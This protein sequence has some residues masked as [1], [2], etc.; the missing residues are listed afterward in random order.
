MEKKSS[1]V[2][3]LTNSA[4]SVDSFEDAI[5]SERFAKYLA[6]AA[7][8]RERAIALYTLNAR[9]SETLYTPLQMLEVA[10]RNRIHSVMSRAFQP[11]WYDLPRHQLNP[12]QLEMIEK[13]KQSLAEERK[14]LAPA[15]IVAA[16]TF[17]YW[18]SM[19][20]SA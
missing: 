17:G 10:L 3:L 16:L 20:G 14:D 13:A 12:R 1:P 19:L 9:L 8:D 11:D 6:W 18:T 4:M 7:G 15:R 5:S 2:L